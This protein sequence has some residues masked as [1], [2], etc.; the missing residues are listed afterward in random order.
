MFIK[1]KYFHYI[2]LSDHDRS[3]NKLQDEEREEIY[4]RLSW[5]D[6]NVGSFKINE[7]LTISEYQIN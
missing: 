3:S 2:K 1:C 6:A 7:P 5:Q 4:I